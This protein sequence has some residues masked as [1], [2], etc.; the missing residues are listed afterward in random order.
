MLNDNRFEVVKLY[1]N[2]RNSLLGSKNIYDP[3][4]IDDVKEMLPDIEK[5]FWELK[6]YFDKKEK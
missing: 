6:S 3:N 1:Q 5:A 2:L 4:Y